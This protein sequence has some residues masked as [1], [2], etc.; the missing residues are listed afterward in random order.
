MR[1][2]TYLNDSLVAG[3]FV[4]EAR[5]RLGE[6]VSLTAGN[7]QASNSIVVDTIDLQDCN[8]LELAQV[9]LIRQL[10]R[11]RNYHKIPDKLRQKLFS[12]YQQTI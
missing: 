11:A 8:F 1:S 2:N 6:F 7:T 9:H 10:K 3:H 5:Y 4:K 12:S